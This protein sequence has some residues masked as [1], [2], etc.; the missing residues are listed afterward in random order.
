MYFL[1]LKSSR[2]ALK[3]EIMMRTACCILSDRNAALSLM[4][5]ERGGYRLAN[6]LEEAR[7]VPRSK[8]RGSV[9]ALL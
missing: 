6:L 2:S 5:A 7:V 4:T 1:Y 8:S 9:S 3:R